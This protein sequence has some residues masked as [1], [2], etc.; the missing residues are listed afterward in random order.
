MILNQFH[1][2]IILKNMK[3]KQKKKIKFKIKNRKKV[4]NI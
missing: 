4:K 3:N 2:K 1:H